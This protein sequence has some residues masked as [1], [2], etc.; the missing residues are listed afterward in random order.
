M[1]FS[2]CILDMDI[3]VYKCGFSIEK[4]DKE[5]DILNV[6]PVVHAYYNVN[7]MVRSA[8]NRSDCDSHVGYITGSGRSN[9]RFDI[10]SDYKANRKE[11]RK[12]VYYNEIREF[13]QGRW[14][15]KVVHGQE[16]DDACSIKQYELNPLGW[17]ENVHNSIIWTIDKDLNNVPGYHGNYT[18]GEISYISPIEALRNFYLQILTGDTSDGIPRIKK[19]WKKKN[20]QEAIGKA[21]TEEEMIQ[22]V[23]KEI[24]LNTNEFEINTQDEFVKRARLVHLRRYEGEL[25]SIPKSNLSL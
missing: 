2:T 19:G 22:I 25:W 15:A 21:E 14:G 7:S 12:P 11:A 1:K 4:Y 18:T 3:L 6:E 5:L 9:F 8:L 10:F 16:A 23:L 13:L 17:D 24:K 20:A